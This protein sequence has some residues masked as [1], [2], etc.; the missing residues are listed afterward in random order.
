NAVPL[1][2]Q[3]TKPWPEWQC[4]EHGVPLEI[5]G[6]ALLCPRGH[7]FPVRD[8]IPRFVP[9]STYADHF[10]AQWNKYRLTQLDSTLGFPYTRDRVRRCAGEALWNR[11]AGMQ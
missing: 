4:P 1:P 2:L 7:S 6:E 11:I 9:P 10:G 3:M 8:G 5:S